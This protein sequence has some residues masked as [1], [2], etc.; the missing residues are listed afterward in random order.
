M[1]VDAIEDQRTEAV[2]RET[3][4][5]HDPIGSP[6]ST[7][8][9][10]VNQQSENREMPARE[11]GASRLAAKL[12]DLRSRGYKAELVQDEEGNMIVIMLPMD[13]GDMGQEP[14]QEV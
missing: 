1:I 7:L 2:L 14:R 8:A 11:L 3:S 12:A 13:L 9:P 4:R 5:L 6:T 10:S